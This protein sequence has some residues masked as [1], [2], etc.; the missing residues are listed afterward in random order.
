MA[1]DGAHL[2]LSSISDFPGLKLGLFHIIT[3]SFQILPLSLSPRLLPSGISGLTSWL[4]V[5]VCA[6]LCEWEFICVCVCVRKCVYVSV[7]LSV[8]LC[9]WG[10][11]WEVVCEWL[12]ECVCICE[13]V[14]VRVCLCVS[15]CVLG[16]WE[17]LF[18]SSGLLCWH[19]IDMLCPHC[20]VLR[21]FEVLAGI[22]KSSTW[23]GLSGWQDADGPGHLVI[24]STL[25]WLRSLLE[26]LTLPWESLKTTDKDQAKGKYQP[27]RNQLPKVPCYKGQ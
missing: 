7:Y 13:C 25:T 18:W 16:W 27:W 5:C 24:S 23:Q 3:T 14:Y 26:S 20:Q 11:V 22:V 15:A 4:C 1:L 19:L 6:C 9:E 21:V 2:S 8:C 12:C 10:Y 17:G